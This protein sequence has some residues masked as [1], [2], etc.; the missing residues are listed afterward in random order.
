MVQTPAVAEDDGSLLL[1]GIA[2]GPST[3]D[4][5]GGLEDTLAEPV[6]GLAEACK[7]NK[8]RKQAGE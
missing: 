7:A 8:T 4:S 3:Q 5:P 6:Q 2:V 1:A